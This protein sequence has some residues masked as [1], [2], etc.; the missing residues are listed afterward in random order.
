MI[1]ESNVNT[2]GGN[3]MMNKLIKTE[4]QIVILELSL[5]KVKLDLEIVTEQYAH[6]L[7]N[8]ERFEK[9]IDC[10]IKE[11]SN[12]TRQINTKKHQVENPHMYKWSDNEA[13]DKEGNR[14]AF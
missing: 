4:S 9:H 7:I 2:L 10:L 12:I 6:E 13:Y 8:Q 11:Q 3:D 5:K 1:R 14:V